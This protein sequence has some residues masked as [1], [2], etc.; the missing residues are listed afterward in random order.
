[1][2]YAA[3]LIRAPQVLGPVQVLL[4]WEAKAQRRWGQQCMC[5]KVRATFFKP[6]PLAQFSTRKQDVAVEQGN[7]PVVEE[8]KKKRSES[9]AHDSASETSDTLVAASLRPVKEPVK[10]G[11]SYSTNGFL[12]GPDMFGEISDKKIRDLAKRIAVC[13][14]PHNARNS[15]SIELQTTGLAFRTSFAGQNRMSVRAL[16]SVRVLVRGLESTLNRFLVF[17]REIS[18]KSSSQVT[19]PPCA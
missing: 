12:F 1:M 3:G 14:L 15:S 5:R 17:N 7:D 19:G 10:H 18:R 16:V 9:L 11:S 2:S 13:P 8:K 4:R 6:C